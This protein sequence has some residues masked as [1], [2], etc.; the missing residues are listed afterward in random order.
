MINLRDAAAG[1]ASP[2]KCQHRG[3]IATDGDDLVEP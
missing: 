1:T 3:A 2:G